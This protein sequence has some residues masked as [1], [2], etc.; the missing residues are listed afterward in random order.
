M[1][2]IGK[3]EESYAIADGET[4]RGLAHMFLEHEKYDT[5]WLKMALALLFMDSRLSPHLVSAEIQVEYPFIYKCR[6]SIG[7]LTSHYKIY[8]SSLPCLVQNYMGPG[9]MI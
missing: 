3:S 1:T 7:K 4:V 5:T 2:V 8:R 9:Q 6:F